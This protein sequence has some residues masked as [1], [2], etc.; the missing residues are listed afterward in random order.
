MEDSKDTYKHTSSVAKLDPDHPK[1]KFLAIATLLIISLGTGF[2]GGWLATKDQSGSTI[3]KQQVVLKNQGDFI[4]Y[5]V[6]QVGPSV[7][8]V[9][10]TGTTTVQGFFGPTQQEQQGAGTGIILNED[11]LIMTN[12]HVVPEGTTD[13]RIILADGTEFKDVTVVG[14]TGSSESLDVAFLKIKD[15]KGKKLTAAK[16]GDSSKMK[17]GDSVVAIGNALGQFQNTVTSGIISGYG[18]NLQ[19]SDG[20]GTENL[21]NL[22][23]TDAAINPG[24]SGGPLV[25]L[26]GEV[27]GINTAVASGDAQN[28][29]FSIPINDVVGLIDT[30][31][32]TGKLER[33]YLGVTYQALTSDWAEKFGLSVKRG[34]YILPPA[35]MQN[36]A[37][38]IAEGSPAEKAGLRA[39]DIITKVDDKSVD[40]NSS[41]SSI[42]NK[43]KVGDKV[44]L[45]VVRDGKDKK[46]EVT[47]GAV[48]GT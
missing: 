48:P 17:V 23:Q 2:F 46:I 34:A 27:V 30:V 35:Y 18:R 25:N 5:I 31:K 24:N 45:T 13:V 12:R 41:L 37:S 1:V 8:S 6:D 39:G 26:E 11:G 32:T 42:L 47:L 10:T 9:E 43:H 44:T 20:Q 36:N 14:R 16:I 7:V 22:F 4:G 38:P 19:A 21:E 28:L 15:T 3:E 40:E 29:G 33:P